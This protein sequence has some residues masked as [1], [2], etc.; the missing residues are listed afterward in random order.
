M[1]QHL[2]QILLFVNS[3]IMN[4]DKNFPCE[5]LIAVIMKTNVF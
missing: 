1:W 5:I 3:T 4:T 2:T